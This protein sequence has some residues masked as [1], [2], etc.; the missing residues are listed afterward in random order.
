[1]AFTRYYTADGQRVP[2]VTTICKKIAWNTEGLIRWAHKVGLA[3]QSLDDARQTAT[4]TGTVAHAMIEASIKGED[5]D[6][7]GLPAPVI[8][9]ARQ[10]FE[11]WREWAELV[12]FEPIAAE[13]SLVSEKHRYG[14]TFDCVSVNGK[15][16]LTD[17]KTSLGLYPDHLLQV[18]AYGALWDEH[19]PEQPIERFALLRLGKDDPA[20][21]HRVRD[22]NSEP[23]LAAW[24]MFVHARAQYDLAKIVER[25]SR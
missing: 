23:M 2:S 19:H 9:G 3:G 7:S 14:G 5:A 4:T 17:W 1:M 15:V 16:T 8:E 12:R 13:Q 21:D 6:I 20:F 24:Q 11:T 18:A 25:A 22:P 10:A